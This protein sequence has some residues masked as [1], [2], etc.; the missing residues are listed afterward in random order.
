LM[1]ELLPAFPRLRGLPASPS[2]LA[3]FE[4]HYHRRWAARGREIRGLR[5]ERMAEE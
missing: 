1:Q 4:S 3:V 5:I 2:E